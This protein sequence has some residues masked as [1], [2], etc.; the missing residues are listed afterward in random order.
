MVKVIEVKLLESHMFTYEACTPH[1]IKFQNK[2]SFQF[3]SNDHV[4]QPT[5]NNNKVVNA[6]EQPLTK[7][8]FA[9]KRM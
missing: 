9:S 1:S 4:S 3:T 5:N 7:L 6:I 2:P 8:V